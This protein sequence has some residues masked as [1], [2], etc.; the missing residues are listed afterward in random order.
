MWEYKNGN[1]IVRIF[2]DGTKMRMSENPIPEYPESIDV[3]ITNKC[4]AGCLFCHENS[5]IDG[6]SFDVDFA[7]KLFKDLPKGIELAIGGGNPLECKQD[8]KWLMRKCPNPIYNLTINAI[9][10]DYFKDL[11]P[12][13]IGISYKKELHQRIK[14]FSEQNSYKQ[15]VIHLIAGVHSLEDL[16]RCI[17][18]FDRILV[19]GYKKF[20]RG[21]NFYNEGI[22]KEI[23]KW[24]EKI[25]NYFYDNQKIIA[26]DNLALE[27]L[28]IKRFF[29][30][31]KWEGMYMGEDGEFSMYLDLVEKKFAVSSTSEKKF[32]I[33][34]LSIREMFRSLKNKTFGA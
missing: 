24:C 7:Y 31:K 22:E 4:N 27:Q 10:L 34:E 9:H 28:D 25:G 33:N 2:D 17:R 13:A 32:D 15:I 21:I 29:T 8:L 19:L 16:E 23:R 11:Y 1:Y 26:F 30:P 6:D 18:D 5:T 12:T 20:G 14:E 3:K